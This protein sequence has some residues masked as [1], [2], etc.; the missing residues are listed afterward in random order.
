MTDPAPLTPPDSDISDF[1]FMPLDVVRFRNSDLVAFEPA[2][3]I[4]AALMLW[5]VAWHSTPAASLTDDD[6]SLAQAA[7]F[8]RAVKE[9][10]QVR[11][12]ALRGFIKCSDGRLYHP[13]VAEKANEAWKAK[14]RRLWA[15][16]CAAI[17][18][19]NERKD[20]G[21]KDVTPSFEEW[22]VARDAPPLSQ[23]QP[24]VSRVTDV[25]VTRD[26]PPKNAPRDREGTGKGQGQGESYSNNNR[27][28]APQPAELRKRDVD[29]FD[30]MNITDGLARRAGVPHSQPTHVARNLDTVRQW[31]ADGIDMAI[32][33]QQID[34]FRLDKPEDR[35]AS[36]LFFDQGVRAVVA[37]KA[38]R[39]RGGKGK[40]T[41][42]VSTIAA[43]PVAPLREGD[44]PDPR[45]AT[46]RRTFNGN[47]SLAPDKVSL[48]LGDDDGEPM[49]ILVARS[50]YVKSQLDL[51]PIRHAARDA[52]GSGVVEV[53]VQ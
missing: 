34:R 22:L 21:Q 32:V 35:V 7:G 53:R 15:T 12:G 39:E 27:E 3:S 11:E 28:S 51:E 5:G 24:A 37:G 18:K 40:D 10:Q 48:R 2:E 44:D 36:L 30:V 31:H 9:W 29:P 20:D 52:L 26:T 4:L 50:A 49:L 33:E 42:F 17:R 19:R 25:K 1:G 13:V 14:L 41:G 16:H 46:I 47:P 6:R 8:G 38:A 43:P 45:I 23:A